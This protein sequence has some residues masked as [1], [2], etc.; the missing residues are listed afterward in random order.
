MWLRASRGRGCWWARS[1]A[2]AP[3]HRRC[4]WKAWW[5]DLTT[6][7]C[8]SACSRVGNPQEAASMS[9]HSCFRPMATIL[10]SFRS[11]RNWCWKCPSD[12]PSKRD[13]NGVGEG[14]WTCPVPLSAHSHTPLALSPAQTQAKLKGGLVLILT[15]GLGRVG[16]PKNQ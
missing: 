7:G 4:V 11:L 8:R 10:S 9:C 15:V 14:G 16:T 12:T 6:S 2:S 13:G 1:G 3:P 5:P